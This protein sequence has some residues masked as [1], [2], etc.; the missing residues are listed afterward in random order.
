MNCLQ[1]NA[2]GLWR[3]EWSR[4]SIHNRLLSARGASSRSQRWALLRR[5]GP[6][7]Q[8]RRRLFVIRKRCVR[9]CAAD[10][11][12]RRCALPSGGVSSA[13]A[14]ASGHCQSRRR[15][16][17]HRAAGRVYLFI[18]GVPMSQSTME[19]FAKHRAWPS[20]TEGLSQNGLSQNGY[21]NNSARYV[22]CSNFRS[23]IH[24]RQQW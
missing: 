10:G 3:C 23:N 24:L 22:V 19:P 2:A 14:R 8:G 4:S 7:Y 9:L 17:A 6:R 11:G 20:A 5:R 18:L 13:H 12:C 16:C 21:G 1:A 15:G